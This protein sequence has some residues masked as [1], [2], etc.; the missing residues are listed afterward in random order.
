MQLFTITDNI[1][2][3]YIDNNDNNNKNINEFN[4][5]NFECFDFNNMIIENDYIYLQNKDHY[6]NDIN[7]IGKK[8][9]DDLI[10]NAELFDSCI[11]FNTLGYLKDT[12]DLNKLIELNTGNPNDGLFINIKKYNNKYDNKIIISP[13]NKFIEILNKTIDEKDKKRKIKK[14]VKEKT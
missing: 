13:K 12:V 2:N 5:N 9:I 8:D 6:G 14:P 7:Y 10:F 3:K 4:L 1:K 11:A